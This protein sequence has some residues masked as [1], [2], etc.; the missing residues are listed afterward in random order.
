MKYS[1]L[2]LV[3]LINICSCT[4]EKYGSTETHLINTT[5]HQI[6]ILGFKNGIMKEISAIAPNETVLV[7]KMRV[8]GKTLYPNFGTLLQPYD[9]VKVVYD[10]SLSIIHQRFNN[11]NQ[12]GVTYENSRNLTN[13]D[14]YVMVI[15]K[16][17]KYSI[18]G[19]FEFKFIEQ[20]FL[21]ASQ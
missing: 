4:I 14:N 20:D 3:I 1:I 10:N 12:N 11:S 21:D 9:S 7:L 8:K 15:T 16:E 17:D 5:E 6:K 2:I 19:N 18:T 13:P